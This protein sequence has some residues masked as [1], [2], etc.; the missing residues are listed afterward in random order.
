[1]TD[2]ETIQDRIGKLIS[3]VR[4]AVSYHELGYQSGDYFD[5]NTMIYHMDKLRDAL[6]EYDSQEPRP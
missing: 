5:A 6:D 1:M 3:K 4:T 2:H